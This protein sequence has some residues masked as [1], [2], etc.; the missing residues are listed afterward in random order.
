VYNT[1]NQHN[2]EIIEWQVTGDWVVQFTRDT[3]RNDY[4]MDARFRRRY[5]GHW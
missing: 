1:L 2:R 3:A 5:E 4:A